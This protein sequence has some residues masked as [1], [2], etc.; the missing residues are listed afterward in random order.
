MDIQLTLINRSDDTGNS[1]V[2]I[3]QRNVATLFD[4]Q[5]VAWKV[6]PTPERG[7]RYKFAF[8][9]A[10]SAAAADAAGGDASEPVAASNGTL[11]SAVDAG[12]GVVLR[13]LG[14]SSS[15]K[16][17]QVQNL[18]AS[19]SID[20]HIYKDGKLLAIK[21]SIAPQ[22]KAVFQFKPTIW[23]GVV[24]D[25][26]AGDVLDP[27]V[28]AQVNTEL[29]LIGIARADIVMTGGGSGTAARPFSFSLQNVVMAKDV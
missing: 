3:F 24:A 25:V 6:I 17:I 19:G 7:S 15:A 22:Q 20:A 4:E 14:S 13:P 1:Q 12:Q 29:A 21:T 26:Q 16:E 11:L 18:R 8:P 9:T 23:I 28:L 27:T 2:V 10:N 5:A